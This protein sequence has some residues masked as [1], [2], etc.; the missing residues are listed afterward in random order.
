MAEFAVSFA[1]Q[2]L[3]NLLVQEIKLLTNV[4]TEV[5]SIK[6]ELEFIRSFLR[7]ADERAAEEES[8]E[9]NGGVISTWVKQ[10]R[11]EA[12]HIED[13]L[14]EYMLKEAKLPRGS[15]LIRFLK[16]LC[17]II[18]KLKVCHEIEDIKLS[19]DDIRRKADSYN[20]R[21]IDQRS[22]SGTGD[23]VPHDSRV[24]S[25]FIP[26]EEVVGIESTRDKLI[27]SLVSGTSHRSVFAVV[28]EGGLGKTTLVGKIYDNDT[29]KKHF[30]CR[31]RITVGKEYMK[32]DLLRAI[33]RQFYSVKKNDL[34]TA[35]VETREMEESHL[36]ET[37]NEQ[38]KDKCYLLVFDDVWK[39]QFW[40]DIE[41]A[42]IDNNKS[43]R[44]II[45]TRNKDVAYSVPS[46]NVCPLQPLPSDKAFELFRR[47]AFGPQGSC[48][49][50]LEKLSH[51]ILGKCEGLPVAIVAA[52]GL[53]SNKNKDALEWKRL[54]DGL[55][56]QLGRD[57]HFK[58]CNRVLLEGYYS[59][60]HHLKS[61]LLYFGLFPE[62]HSIN[63]AR[64]I[65]LWI[66][67][68]FVPYSNSSTS[69]QVA[70]E[71]LSDL[72]NRSLVQVVKRDSVGRP[73]VCRVHDLM[74][75]II[76]RKTDNLGFSTLVNGEGSSRYWKT[77]RISINGSTD[78]VLESIK[79][80]K[81]RS[82]F[83][84][85]IDKMPES[86]PSALIA[87]F[88]L[89]KVLDF[90]D[91]PLESLPE[92]VGN[93]FHLHYLSV[94]NTKVKVLPQSIGKLL[95]LETLNLKC[96]L[97]NELP[98]GIKN[99]K[100]LRYL[101]ACGVDSSYNYKTVKVAE[102]LGSL[103]DLQK[104]GYVDANFVVLKE[105]RKLSHL[106]KLAIKMPNGNE[107]DLCAC[108]ENM[109]KLESLV[110]SSTS[111]EEILDIESMASPPKC[112]QR[113]Y[114]K[115]NMKK[116]PNWVFKL[117]NIVRIVLNLSGLTDDPMRV[118]QAVP[119]LLELRLCETY[120]EEQL[121][122]KEGWFPK[123]KTLFLVDFKRVESMMIDN[124]AMP[125][126]ESLMIKRCPQLKEIPVGIEHLRNLELLEFHFMLRNIY[127]M[128]KDE[129]WEKV[130]QHIL[131]VYATFMFAG[132]VDKVTTKY[133]SSLSTA[134]FEAIEQCN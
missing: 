17:C 121:H 61:S 83:L 92:G 21:S 50:E 36:I 103:L 27:G 63:C 132:H 19:L 94:K 5:E 9:R 57:S 131:E 130:T 114:L 28:G 81:I 104:L 80:S 110:I 100:K 91:G 117:K 53:L 15:G 71:F 73:R 14:D 85:N 11:E 113:I 37:L 112:L 133:L 82:V 60:P 25:Y 47:K 107:K 109:E 31:A 56:T 55:G 74:H 72:I 58:D 108:I 44:I 127:R 20:F 68:G 129:K 16:K 78:G 3:G 106:R 98:A 89:I 4:K 43:S 64:L 86:F 102:G 125:N 88:E 75:E 18:N 45:T 67:E 101:L 122:I 41:H 51:D 22:S 77:R 79:N 59:L 30:D 84:F 96:S 128:I 33:I 99:L 7:D 2:H 116:L 52:G 24:G 66:A 40:G 35:P 65:R 8:A 87:G 12:Y 10:V 23:I 70:E 48:P 1:L 38:L 90:E 123:L 54:R 134:H 105:L 49:P 26:E 115:G 46:V 39:T 69:E 32:N 111:R 76:L 6:R 126:L 13:V 34:L 118:L 93:L 95:N 124:G 62:S 120:H 97:V 29:V 119:N 42:L